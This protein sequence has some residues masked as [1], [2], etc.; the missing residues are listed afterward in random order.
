MR[1]S[2]QEQQK[3]HLLIS[4][5]HQTAINNYHHILILESL[6]E[7][8]II[9][10]K[11]S[12]YTLGRSQKNSLYIEDLEVSRH[13]A[14][15]VQESLNSSQIQYRIYDGKINGK[16]STNGLI[17]NGQYCSERLL[18]PK[19][20]ILLGKNVRLSYH[21]LSTKAFQLIK[22]LAKP[23]QNQEKIMAK[24]LNFSKKTL[25]KQP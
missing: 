3:N 17:V 1:A 16:K 9:E 10:L 12:H 20:S 25:L 22:K 2:L 14:T 13:H 11:L 5:K 6:F 4:K 18:K 23:K 7:S 19:D 24:S 21:Q 15:I 8:Q